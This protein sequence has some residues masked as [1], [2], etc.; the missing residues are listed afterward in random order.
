MAKH[1]GDNRD[2]IE[3]VKDQTVAIG[4]Y[5]KQI[6]HLTQ[7]YNS[8]NEEREENYLSTKKELEM[9]RKAFYD[10]KVQYAHMSNQHIKNIKREPS[11]L[12]VAISQSKAQHIPTPSEQELLRENQFLKSRIGLLQQKINNEDSKRLAQHNQLLLT[13]VEELEQWVEEL[14]HQNTVQ[15][16]NLTQESSPFKTFISNQHRLDQ[17]T[18]ELL[19]LK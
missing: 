9:V 3:Q 11:D 8:N 12:S 18:S 4:Q 1:V 10:L 17:Q 6:Q 5:K 15:L 19:Q 16:N 7:Q 2:L 13:K 14:T